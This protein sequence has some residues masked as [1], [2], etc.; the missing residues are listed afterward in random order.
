LGL[1]FTP[2]KSPPDL[3]PELCSFGEQA[4]DG[5]KNASMSSSANTGRQFVRFICF[6][7]FGI[8]KRTP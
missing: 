7:S 5:N 4:A 8:K 1:S 2:G 6:P 3:P